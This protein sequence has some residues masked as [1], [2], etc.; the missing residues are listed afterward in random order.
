M[1]PEA[2]F[3]FSGISVTNASV[4]SV[5]AEI[6]ARFAAPCG[7]YLVGSTPPAFN[8][9]SYLPVATLNPS[10][11]LRFLTT[12]TIKAP[13]WPALLASCRVGNADISLLDFFFFERLN[14]HAI[15]ES[16]H[17]DS[18]ALGTSGGWRTQVD[19]AK[20][21]S[22]ASRLSG[23]FCFSDVRRRRNLFLPR[24]EV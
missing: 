23:S 19:Q 10:F 16:F 5:R 20:V 3:S 1:P 17:I 7:C 14:Q 24:A 13:S 12:W 21:Y 2:G 4:V 15:A 11:P 22:R 18:G 9:P 8:R 6:K